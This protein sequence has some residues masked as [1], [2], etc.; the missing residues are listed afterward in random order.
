M[1]EVD[2]EIR[3]AGGEGLNETVRRV[4]SL[5]SGTWHTLRTR[6]KRSS[7]KSGIESM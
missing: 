5:Q 1:L 4:I 6:A 2:A 3:D 7:R